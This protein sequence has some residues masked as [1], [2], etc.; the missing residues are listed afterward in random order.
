VEPILFTVVLLAVSVAFA[1]SASAG[2]GG[3]LDTQIPGIGWYDE[4]CKNE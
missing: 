4:I 3:D 2:F 1:V